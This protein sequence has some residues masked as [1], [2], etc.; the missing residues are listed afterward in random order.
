MGSDLLIGC[1]V[2][3]GALIGLTVLLFWSR[4]RINKIAS[5]KSRTARDI[6]K[7]LEK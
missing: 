1:I 3:A 5:M 4:A 2:L 6:L 7:D